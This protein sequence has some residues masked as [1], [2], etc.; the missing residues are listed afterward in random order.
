M[1][2]ERLVLPRSAAFGKAMWSCNTEPLWQHSA[3]KSHASGCHSPMLRRLTACLRQQAAYGAAH[4]QARST[5][6][7]GAGN[8]NCRAWCC[9]SADSGSPLGSR[10]HEPAAAL[11][12][13]TP[14]RACFSC[15]ARSP[16]CCTGPIAKVMDSPPWTRTGATASAAPAAAQQG[17]KDLTKVFEPAENE[18]RLYDWCLACP[19][20]GASIAP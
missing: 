11:Q 12:A 18:Q 15:A 3:S 14:Q 8:S 19:V 6:R 5:G 4:S 1:R 20:A 9:A 16:C 7:S 17:R 10:K 2:L 13:G